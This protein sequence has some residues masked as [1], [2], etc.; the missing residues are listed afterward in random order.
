[1]GGDDESELSVGDLLD[2]KYLVVRRIGA[3]AM[4]VVHAVKRVTL[5]DVVAVKSLLRSQNTPTNRARFIREAQAAARIRHPNVVQVFDFASPAR[6]TPYLVMEYLDGPTLADALAERRSMPLAR[7][8]A[9]F[10]RV[11]AAVEAGHRRGVVHRDLKPGNVI[12]ARSDDGRET[13]KVLDFGLAR[14]LGDPG[15]ELT[16]PGTLLGTIAYMAPEQVSS[17]EV[18]P[19]SD[20]FALGV[21]LYELVTGVLPFRGEHHVATLLAI[22]QGEF[23]DPRERVPELPESVASAIVAALDRDRA[24]RPRSAEALASMA[25]APELEPW[26]GGDSG[27]IPLGLRRPASSREVDRT[28]A[29]PPRRVQLTEGSVRTGSRPTA[30]VVR[31]VGLV[32]RTDE[33][34]ELERA[35]AAA[36]DQAAAIVVVL[37]E[38]GVG[39]SRLVDE[40]CRRAQAGGAVVLRG[41]FFAYEGDRPPP[42]AAFQWMLA[43]TI[44]DDELAPESSREPPPLG[45]SEKWQVFASLAQQFGARARDARLVVRLDDL[46]WAS[47]PELDFLAYLPHALAQQSVLVVGTAQPGAPELDRWLS[48]LAAKRALL[49]IRLAPWS[50]DEVRQFL[51]ELLGELRIRPQD[52]RR[53]VH[54]T[55]GQPYAVIELVGH[56]LHS[57]AITAVPSGGHE[58]HDLHDVVLPETVQGLLEARYAGLAPELLALLEVACVTGEHFRFEALWRAAELGEDEVERLLE[59]AIGHRLLSDRKVA[60][61]CDYRFATP[62]LRAVLYGR[63]PLRRR[64]RVHARVVDVLEQLYADRLQPIAHV[65]AYH[66]HAI[67][68]W[69]ACLT[70]ALVAATQAVAVHDTDLAGDCLRWAGESIDRLADAG[71]PAQPAVRARFD[72]LAGALASTIGRHE[73][74]ELALRRAVVSA[75]QVGDRSL[76]LDAMLALVECLLGR[77]QFQAGVDVGL[78][79][80]ELAR[81]LGDRERHALGCVR[82][83]GCAGPLGRIELAREVLAPVLADEAIAP[84]LRALAL[85][86]VAW[87]EAKAGAFAAAARAGRDALAAATRARDALAQYRAVSVLGLVHAEAG[88]LAAAVPQLQHALAL[89]RALSLRRREGIELANISECRHLGGDTEGALVDA[90]AALEIFVEIGDRASEGD[91][92]VNVGRMLMVCG[93]RAEAIAMLDAAREAC[94]AS[95]RTEYEG[96]A[97]CELGDARAAEAAYVQARALYERAAGCFDRIGHALAWRAELGYAHMAAALGELELARARAHSALARIDEQLAHLPEGAHGRALERAKLEATRLLAQHRAVHPP[98]GGTLAETLAEQH[99]EL[100]RAATEMLAA[101]EPARILEDPQRVLATLA[102]FTRELRE[103]ARTENEALYPALLAHGDRDIRERA[104]AL[105]GEGLGL[106]DELFAFVEQWQ[107]AELLA[108]QPERFSAELR[109]VLRSLGR[110]MRREDL[111]LHPLAA[112]I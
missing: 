26:V 1:V 27:E 107:D 14:L 53:I 7:A 75:Q 63:I 104:A 17:G 78:R 24:R 56:L 108:A 28:I 23:V 3:G 106:Y 65:L 43:N 90:R 77:G 88:D 8:L 93:R 49:S 45:S 73:E 2:D 40:L 29:M 4:G 16:R 68:R 105:Y 111:E 22:S 44:V 112:L 20:L 92:R 13:V 37:G 74:A 103:H 38:A 97:L 102:D 47:G 42:Y 64:R 48:T 62:G 51:G 85:R 36:P 30:P 100:E 95:G 12:L 110:R 10:G 83:A 9:V 54:V 58:C 15:A 46:Q 52:L 35:F 61:G 21:M 67:E 57:H 87:I 82:V 96:I 81:A 76:A 71:T 34:A 89:A 59:Q 50:L 69:Q 55:G 109:T 18:T 41:Q 80:T 91:C 11:C 39:K 79:A 66:L 72:H 84:V 5:G 32:G 19:A 99:A 94:A 70:Q 6:R 98:S 31:E 60:P 25:G 101:L 33:L 86:E